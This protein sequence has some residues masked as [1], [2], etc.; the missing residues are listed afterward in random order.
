M[1]TNTPFIA[2]SAGGG[3]L[4]FLIVLSYFSPSVSFFLGSLLVGHNILF[5][6]LLLLRGPLRDFGGHLN[7]RLCL[8]RRPHHAAHF[9]AAAYREGAHDGGLGAWLAPGAGSA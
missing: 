4:L 3:A 8:R 2:L 5:G 1:Q 9:P 7:D 6:W